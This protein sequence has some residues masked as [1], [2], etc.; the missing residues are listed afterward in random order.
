MIEVGF[1]AGA[2]P[3]A[4]SAPPSTTHRI[5]IA[6]VSPQHYRVSYRGRTLAE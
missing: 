3:L 6:I 1:P 5:D 4:S 2:V